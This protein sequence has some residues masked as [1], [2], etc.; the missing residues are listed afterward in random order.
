MRGGI[1]GLAVV[2]ASSALTCHQGGLPEEKHKMDINNLAGIQLT[3]TAPDHLRAA[4]VQQGS[5]EFDMNQT[6]FRV[7]LRNVSTQPITLPFD[8]IRRNVVR[9]YTNLATSVVHT[10]NRIP[11]PTR[12]GLVETLAPGQSR[13]ITVQFHYPDMLVS[14]TDKE[15]K[16]RFCVQWRREW[17]RSQYYQPGS[18]QWNEPFD[19]C[20]D[21]RITIS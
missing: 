21:I 18:Y 11:P 7:T 1:G 20:K 5:P 2:V 3:I 16:L 10:D 9:V 14:S 19:V 4:A 13:E 12:K 15:L 6:I 17:L 8:E